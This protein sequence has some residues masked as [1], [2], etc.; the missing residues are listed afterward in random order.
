MSLSIFPDG[1]ENPANLARIEEAAHLLGAMYSPSI[2]G[3]L[4]A[5]ENA[6][7][8]RTIYGRRPLR[9]DATLAVGNERRGLSRKRLAEADETVV[10]PT[11][12]RT[13]TTLNV[14]AA[15]AVAGWYVLRGSSAQAQT[16]RPETRRPAL[17][18]IGED[19]VEVGSS[20]RSAAAFGFRDV[21]L[22]D[23]GA[24]WFDGPAAARR[25]AFAAARRHKN[26]LRVHRGT[27]QSAARFDEIVFVM[28]SGCATRLQRERLARGQRQLVIV[29][30]RPEDVAAIS[31]DR[32]R[33]AALDLE[34]VERPPLR[35][36]ASILLAEIARQVG[37]RRPV[38]GR[39]GPRVPAYDSALP[40]APADEVLVV[41]AERLLDY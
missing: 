22:E 8:A 29:G 25:E 20:L 40:L 10:I 36:V 26:A 33:L 6:P 7:G 23:R 41:E 37:R 17:L 4:I 31:A 30:A 27:L 14:A 12:S 39:P 24:G 19:H 11:L 38:P 1:V 21:L 35:L 15:A 16:T 34:P 2:A 13:I 18:I 3:R 9:G 32:V 5:V 28:P